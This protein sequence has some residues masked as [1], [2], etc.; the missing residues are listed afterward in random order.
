MI[1][2]IRVAAMIVIIMISGMISPQACTIFKA[3]EGDTVWAGNNEDWSNPKSRV[4]F[5]PA[6]NGKHGMICFGFDNGFIQGSMNTEGLFWDWFAGYQANWKKDSGKADYEGFLS[7][8][9]SRECSTV[10]EAISIYNRYNE[11]NFDYARTLIADKSGASVI[12][13]WIDGKVTA[14]KDS[15]K[16]QVLG[17]GEP[18][19]KPL[20]K[21][22]SI[23]TMEF[24]KSLLL[25][26]HQEGNYPTQYSNLYDLKKG[27]VYLYHRYNFEKVVKFNLNEELKKGRKQYD[28]P[29]LLAEKSVC[30]PDI[31]NETK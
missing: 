15:G 25:A 5:L 23:F 2:L 27:D 9:I 12:I 16:F 3:T 24:L 11:P 14:I 8:K 13:G 17:Y 4:W 21:P 31:L 30:N 28:I 22:D 26:A 6:E 29:D 1:N 7:E 18:R 10:D 19:I 20:L